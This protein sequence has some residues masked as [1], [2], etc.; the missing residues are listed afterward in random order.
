MHAK[1]FVIDNKDTVVGTYNFDPRS[2]NYN[3]EMIISC[4]NN[5]EIAKLVTDDVEMRMGHAF[6]LDSSDKVDETAFYKVG[7][8]KRLA[9]GVLKIPS[10]IFDYLL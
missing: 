5:A 1:T 6:K 4:D 2:A 9:Y 8:L 7:F 10:N 3:A